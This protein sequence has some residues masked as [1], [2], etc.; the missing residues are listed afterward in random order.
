MKQ[1]L[2][3]TLSIAGVVCAVTT[4]VVHAQQVP[5]PTPPRKF[6]AQRQAQP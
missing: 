1:T 3:R 6:L 4:T 5:I 2:L